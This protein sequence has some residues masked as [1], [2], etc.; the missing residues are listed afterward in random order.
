MPKQPLRLGRKGRGTAFDVQQRQLNQPQD[1]GERGAQFMAHHAQKF[2]FAPLSGFLLSGVE[3]H[4]QRET[5]L[6]IQQRCH[7]QDWHTTAVF[8]QELPLEGRQG[9]CREKG[10]HELPQCLVG[11]WG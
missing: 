2:L 8:A 10:R 5:P 11:F 6:L 3:R 4:P 1:R 7:C 9:S